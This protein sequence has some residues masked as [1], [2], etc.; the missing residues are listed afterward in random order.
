[1]L[2]TLIPRH[3]AID[4][5]SL[6]VGAD[7]AALVGTSYEVLA[8]IK[9]G[10][11]ASLSQIVHPARGLLFSPYATIAE[12]SAKTFS[13]AEVMAFGEDKNVY[14]WGVYDGSALPISLTPRE[15]FAEFVLDC[16]Y[17]A[18]AGIVGV[19]RTVRTGNSL[20]NM[21]EVR[22][23]VRYVEFHIPPESDGADWRSLRLGFEEFNGFLMLSVILHSEN[24]V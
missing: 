6:P 23:E 17:A 24:T 1:M 10:D 13:P 22:P 15:Y 14:V 9:S 21:A 12:G 5:R 4:K 20:E 18:R 11:F 8:C 3:R 7:N 16:D 2:I 19:N